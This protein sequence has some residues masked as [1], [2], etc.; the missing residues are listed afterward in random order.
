MSQAVD[1]QHVT[2]SEFDVP[3]RDDV[4]LATDVYFPEGFDG[5]PLP[6]ILERTPYNKRG[7]SRWE[8]LSEDS[9][10][11]MTREA[12]ARAMAHAGYIVVM[13]DCRGRYCSQGSFTKYVNEANDGSDTLEWLQTQPWCN[14]SIGTMGMSY[15]AHTQSALAA[16]NPPGLKCMV[17]DSGGFWNA[18]HEGIRQGGAFE[19][20]QAIWAHRHAVKQ[21]EHA[22]DT[23]T[24]ESLQSKDLWHWLEQMP[25]RSGLSPVSAAPEYEDYMFQQWSRSEYSDYWK[26]PGLAAQEHYPNFPD[27]PVLVIGSWYDPYVRTTVRHFQSLSAQNRSPIHVIM[28]PW[29]HGA[30]VRSYSGDIDFGDAAIFNTHFQAS[31]LDYRLNWFDHCLKGKSDEAFKKNSVS[32]FLMGGDDGHQTGDGRIRHGGDWQNSDAFPPT[33]CNAR[34][35]DLTPSGGLAEEAKNLTESSVSFRFDPNDPTPSIGGAI[36]S[37]EPVMFGGSFDQVERSDFFGC[38]APGRKLIDRED[39]LCFETEPLTEALDVVGEIEVRLSVSSDCPDTDFHVRLVDV[40]PDPHLPSAETAINIAHGLLRVRYRESW[41]NPTLMTP[42]EIYSISLKLTPTAN[43]FRA[44]NR[45][46]IMIS[47]SSFPHFDVN[48]NTGEAQ[49]AAQDMRVATNRIHF[50]EEHLSCIDVPIVAA[51]EGYE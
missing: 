27:I 42:G 48:P 12:L 33:K 23:K 1:A 3:M 21:A 20:K 47:G 5:T 38:R 6:V 41:T 40:Y 32:Y 8:Y 29:T 14:G 39:V 45:M 26:R 44:G 7:E 2:R 46:R 51:S 36:T 24:L 11:P 31:Y 34:R 10:Q 17:L 43:R 9:A 15:G 28:G 35:F 30:R 13:Q 50:G 37:G 18:F 49:G 19:L 4:R 22:G 16:L 25:W